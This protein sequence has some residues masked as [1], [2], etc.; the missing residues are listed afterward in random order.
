VIVTALVLAAIAALSAVHMRDV[1]RRRLERRAAYDNVLS[2][3]DQYRVTQEGLHYPALEGR[4]RGLPVKLDLVLDDMTWRKLPSLWLK[5]TLLVPNPARGT[6]DFLVRPQGNEFYS[7]SADLPRQLKVPAEWPQHAILCS[8]TG[9]TTPNLASLTPYM[10]AFD[11][12]RTKELLVTPLGLRLVYQAAQAE[13][14][15][16]LVLRQ[17]KFASIGTDAAL[18]SNLLD[19]LIAL[20]ADLD[21]DSDALTEAA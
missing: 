4:Y 16:Y 8:E 12:V 19:R 14:A 10:S 5:A 21:R 18:V 15:E 1:R 17:A 11:D 13:R 6:L 9:A 7:P 2:L 20:A 3:F